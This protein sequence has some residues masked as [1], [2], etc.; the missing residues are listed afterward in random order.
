MSIFPWYGGKFNHL[1][2]ILPKLP[3]THI[4]CEA[5]GGA[6]TVLINREP[7]PVEILND[8][9]SNIY[10][11]FK[12]LQNNY[13]DLI[14]K[15]QFTLWSRKEYEDARK[16]INSEE[17]MTLNS[18]ERARLF[19]IWIRQC[20][21][22]YP[23]SV[24]SFS[25]DAVRR[26]ISQVVSRWLSSID[27]LPEIVARLKTVIIENRN[28]LEVIKDYDSK[29]TL[30]YLDPPYIEDS[31]IAKQVYKFEY[32]NLDYEKLFSLLNTI[33]GKVAI[34]N[35]QSLSLL[36][37]AKGWFLSIDKKKGIGGI[38]KSKSKRQEILLTNYK[39]EGAI[40]VK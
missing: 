8:I 36:K 25:K 32:T 33:L 2:F 6:G 23:N 12:V 9:D 13:E 10:N 3:K 1:G 5:F 19:Y 4:Y 40:V 20:R 38:S 24:W 27:Q 37:L 7:S 26:N 39:V 18:I 31:R 15:L 35:Y 21:S 22:G 28:A 29:D 11:F 34:S 17:Y 14:R 30:F 16:I